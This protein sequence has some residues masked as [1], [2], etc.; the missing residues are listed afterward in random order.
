MSRD[1]VTV[2]PST[3]SER[4]WQLMVRH[5][6]KALPALDAHGTLLG[7]V[8]MHD[9]FVAHAP[10]GE[11]ASGAPAGSRVS[12]LMTAPVLTARPEQ[13]IVDLVAAFSDGGRHHLPVVDEA[14]RLVGMVTQSD[15]VAALFRAGLER[16]A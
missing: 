13:P 8:T 1:V 7:I 15:M 3:P 6:V 10:A 11:A 5:A 16:P 2:Q 12:D 14:R 9:F 4:A